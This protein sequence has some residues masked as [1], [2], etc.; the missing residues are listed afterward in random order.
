MTGIS[1]GLH[2]TVELDGP[3]AR[4]QEILRLAEAHSVGLHP[5]SAH[6]HAPGPPGLVIGYSRPAGH[7]LSGALARL[8]QLVSTVPPS[9]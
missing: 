7:E 8:G 3:L 4:E 5:L 9:A 6:R 2:G 1:A